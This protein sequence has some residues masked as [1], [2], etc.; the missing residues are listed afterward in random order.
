VI[1]AISGLTVEQGIRGLL[2]RRGSAGAGKDEAAKQLVKYHN[3]VPLAF[4]DPLKRFLADTFDWDE[5][6]LWGPSENRAKED[7]RYRLSLPFGLTHEE[8]KARTEYLTARHALQSLGDGWGRNQC[9]ELTWVLYAMRVA[10]KIGGGEYHYDPIRGLIKYGTPG[11]PILVG[12]PRK[13]IVITDLRYKNEAEAVREAGGYLVRVK[14]W[15]PK[16]QVSP[17]HQSEK[18]L[19]EVHDDDFDWILHNRSTLDD[20]WGQVDH[21]VSNLGS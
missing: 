8:M 2:R 20:L 18:D 13:D 7:P 21:M 6:R 3:F 1:I 9:C 10:K 5:D 15:I 19:L 11:C 4:A 12:E 16:I 17:K 14:R